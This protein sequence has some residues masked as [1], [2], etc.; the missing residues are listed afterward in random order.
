[1]CNNVLTWKEKIISLQR[2]DFESKVTGMLGDKMINSRLI[3]TCVQAKIHLQYQLR[4]EVPRTRIAPCVVTSRVA[5][6]AP[7]V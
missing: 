3:I 2:L 6:P 5:S 7:N 4:E 1:M